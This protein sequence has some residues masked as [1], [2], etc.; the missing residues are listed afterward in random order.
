[1]YTPLISIV[2][3]VYN[4]SNYLSEAIDSALRQSYENKEIIVINDGSCDDG[5]TQQIMKNYGEKIRCFSKQNGGVATAL[6]FG[7]Q[8]MKGEYFAWLSHDDVLKPDTLEVYVEYLQKVPQNTILYGNFDLIDET[9][10][11][12]DML[13]FLDMY[14]EEQLENSVC[15][16]VLGCVNGCACL[17]HKSHFA[18][19]GMF[20]EGLKI[21]QDNDM[22]FRIFRGQK[23]KFISKLLCSKRYHSQQ[24]SVTKN[25]YPEEDSFVY[26]SLCALS[27]E[28]IS[29][30]NGNISDFYL[31]LKK[32]VG[33]GRHPLSEGYCKKMLEELKQKET[34]EDLDKK[35]LCQ[36]IAKSNQ[37]YQELERKYEE[38][39]KKYVAK[40]M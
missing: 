24:D 10:K 25:V 7:I 28:E 9:S 21:A 40:W 22:W 12:Y 37:D 6:N 18:R 1:M 15:P 16:V 29:K 35:E 8:N 38:L 5:K 17:I 2:I 33:D 36:L 30:F 34:F 11:P 39:E 26:D 31:N 23:V 20:N 14:T 32:R 3:P 4:G 19:V 13:N 27:L